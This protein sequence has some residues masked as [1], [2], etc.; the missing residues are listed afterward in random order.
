M[1]LSGSRK[2]SQE[3]KTVLS[4]QHRSIKPLLFVVNILLN[5]KNLRWQNLARGFFVL[6]LTIIQRIKCPIICEIFA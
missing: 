5:I 6:D 2:Q 3:K 4:G 1:Q